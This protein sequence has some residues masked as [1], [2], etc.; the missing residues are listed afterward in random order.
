MR[1]R[2]IAV[3]T[4]ALL[5]GGTPLL[6][7]QV[8]DVPLPTRVGVVN[9]NAAVASTGEGKRATQTLQEK[10]APRQ[11]ELQKK[12]REV[13]A[14][15]EKFQ[16]QSTTLS[17]QERRRLTRQLEESQRA[18][19]RDQEDFQADSQIESQDAFNRLVEKMQ[20]I[21]RDY[22]GQNG[23]VLVIDYTQI[24]TFYVHKSID[25]TEDIVRRYDAAHPVQSSSTAAPSGGN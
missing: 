2:W 14:L 24:P 15:Q 20:T 8:A 18:L 5:L 10:F 4:I 21:I 11:E 12:T 9:I 25:I 6:R 3:T 19:K 13:Q 7:A 23:Y 16:Q 22:S 1:G 17:E